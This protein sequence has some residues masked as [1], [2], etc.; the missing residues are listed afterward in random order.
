M[1]PPAQVQIITKRRIMK[2][3]TI[4]IKG[5]FFKY[6]GLF[7]D[8]FHEIDEK[9]GMLRINKQKLTEKYEEYET[10]VFRNWDYYEIEEEED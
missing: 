7:Q 6:P 10:A 8:F 5:S 4:H 3:L 2:I 9:T 1:I